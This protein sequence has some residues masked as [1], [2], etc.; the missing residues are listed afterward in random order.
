MKSV[1]GAERDIILR[2]RAQRC[3]VCITNVEIKA[4]KAGKLRKVKYSLEMKER[5]KVNRREIFKTENG[6][7]EG[8]ASFRVRKHLD[9]PFRPARRLTLAKAG[10]NSKTK[11]LEIWSVACNA[12]EMPSVREQRLDVV[13]ECHQ[14]RLYQKT[15]ISG[16]LVCAKA[17]VLEIGEQDGFR[18]M[19]LD[20]V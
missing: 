11:Y 15:Y 7:A 8:V 20:N 14:R 10:G 13:G 18:V 19:S 16:A 12:V 4:C 2:F 17:T 3:T 6:F 1:E 5:R 9:D